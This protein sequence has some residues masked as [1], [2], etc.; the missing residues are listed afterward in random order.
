MREGPAI[1]PTKG[2]N[3]W[4]R[5]SNADPHWKSS[6]GKYVGST[7]GTV[8]EVTRKVPMEIGQAPPTDPARRNRKSK[9]DTEQH[10]YNTQKTRAMTKLNSIALPT[11][12]Q[13]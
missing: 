6:V 9:Q 11:T 10:H 3:T 13:F 12:P 4:Y 1:T 7:I 5:R 2:M 8:Q